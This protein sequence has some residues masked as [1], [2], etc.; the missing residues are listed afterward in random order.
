M[1][2]WADTLATRL[3]DPFDADFREQLG[4]M[5]AFVAAFTS[6]G[7][8]AAQFGDNDSGRLL[9]VA[10]DD[11]TDHRYL[12]DGPCGFGGRLNRFLL[13]GNLPITKVGDART[14][15]PH[16]GY[17]FMQQGDFWAGM[18]AGPITHGGA[19]AHCDQLSFVLNVAGRDVIVDRGTG[20]YTPDP[21]K[22]NRYR[23]ARSHNVCQINGW[24]Q[25]VFSSDRSGI[26][27]MLD[28]TRS[29]VQGFS[30]E[31][32][33]S[34]WT[35]CHEGYCRFR[36]GCTC[37]RTIRMTRDSVDVTD[38]IDAL[39]RDDVL[40]WFFHI[41]PGIDIHLHEDVAVI[42]LDTRRLG[43]RWEFPARA[44]VEPIFHSPAYGVEVPAKTLVLKAVS[45]TLDQE[46]FRIAFEFN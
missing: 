35:A 29:Q 28:N 41:A 37:R 8:T 16:G 32:D 21:A 9:R 15:F 30:V 13:R 27:R 5:S 39:Q 20:I 4:R 44:R 2:L 19:H 25:N 3:G 11:E 46:G 34:I 40:E 43:I 31:A 10:I 1:F 22:R 7:G 23:S 6:P 45:H 24:E 17:Y 33:K 38:S 14:S 12:T 42:P 18:R 26:F 36:P